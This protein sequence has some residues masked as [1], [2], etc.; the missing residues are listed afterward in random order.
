[1]DRVQHCC[2]GF[3]WPHRLWLVTHPTP[4]NPA[5]SYH[6]LTPYQNFFPRFCFLSCLTKPT[7]PQTKIAIELLYIIIT[8][9][10]SI[11]LF[12]LPLKWQDLITA[13]F[14]FNTYH[15]I[16][17]STVAPLHANTALHL[18]KA[19]IGTLMKNM[20]SKVLVRRN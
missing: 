7:Q 14:I 6:L 16:K 5:H 11:H 3:Y 4:P 1:M 15:S 13:T 10:Y 9:Y 8:I 18:A 20:I 17:Y 19:Y 2:T 12:I